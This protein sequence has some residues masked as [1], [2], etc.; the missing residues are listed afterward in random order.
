MD[1]NILWFLIIAFLYSGYFILEGFDLGV[2]ILLPIISKDNIQRRI[3]LN[4]IGPHWDGN[5]VW[6]ITAGGAT[7]AAFPQWY[8]ALFSGFYL[9]FL[10]ILMGLIFRGA[11]IEF[12]SKDDSHFWRSAC[13][14]SICLG[15]LI[16]AFLWGVAFSNIA[17]GIP[18]DSS[19]NFT[20]NFW[21]LVNPFALLGGFLS[22]II[23][24]FHGAIFLSLKTTGDLETKCRRLSIKLWLPTLLCYLLV[25]IISAGFWGSTK[26]IFNSSLILLFISCVILA[27]TGWL[28]RKNLSKKAFLLTISVILLTTSSFFLW[29]FPN[30]LIS[31]IDTAYNLTI[32]NSSSSPY[33]L[34]IMTIITCIFTPIV[35]LYQGWSYWVFRKRVSPELN[36]LEY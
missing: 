21:Y 13:D 24:C 18:I 36:N 14:W 10:L 2:G 28:I 32:Y 27:I 3:L 35:L 4:T 6:L 7:F 34:K 33:A 9:P 11:A 19:M 17:I 30:L 31:S 25:V 15:S 26:V 1:L 8:A 22:I 20:V 23:F 5:E 29:I 12:R 16:P